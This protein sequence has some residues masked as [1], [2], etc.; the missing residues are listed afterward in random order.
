MCT[1]YDKS[2][3]YVPAS[4]PR[5]YENCCE[6]ITRLVVDSGEGEGKFPG[7]LEWFQVSLVP[8]EHQDHL[9]FKYLDSTG[10]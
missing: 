3:V 4:I 2:Q 6:A 5:T 7:A 1:L 10:L 8:T 9:S